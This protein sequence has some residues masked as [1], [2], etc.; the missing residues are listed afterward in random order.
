MEC[1]HLMDLNINFH[2]M[3][4][5]GSSKCWT[6]CAFSLQTNSKRQKFYI[7]RLE[8]IQVC[9]SQL[10]SS[11]YRILRLVWFD[12]GGVSLDSPR[13][14]GYS[15]PETRNSKWCVW[16][17]ESETCTKWLYLKFRP[18]RVV[19]CQNLQWL[20]NKSGRINL[21]GGFNDLLF[22]PLFG[23]IPILANIFQLGW[24]NHQPVM[25]DVGISSISEL[26]I[27]TL[28][29]Q[30]LPVTHHPT[31]CHGWEDQVV[32]TRAVKWDTSSSAQS[33]LGGFP[34][35]ESGEQ[36]SNKNQQTIIL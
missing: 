25:C 13:W 9:V 27:D 26:P 22:S 35:R 28:T 16:N 10:D 31:S 21:G 23:K 24:F 7:S 1:L 4:I 12:S 33:W 29:P 36:W 30:E 8:K 14:T 3:T 11:W 19:L 2:Y 15:I 18:F 20:G 34:T 17:N 6:K 5:P 32:H